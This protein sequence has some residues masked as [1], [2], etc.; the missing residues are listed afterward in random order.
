MFNWDDILDT[1]KYLVKA[2]ND[3]FDYAAQQVEALKA[4]VSNFVDDLQ[5]TVEAGLNQLVETLGGDPSEVQES[6]FE[7]LEA[8]EWFLSKL[9]GGSKQDNAKPTPKLGTQPSEDSPL[10][11]FLFH[12]I[13]AFEDAV[14]AV[15]RG[16]EGLGETIATL[17]AN[18]LKPQLAVIVMVETLRDVVIQMLGAVENLVLGFLDAI[19]EAVKQ[20]KNLLN[21]EIKIPFI[22]DLFKLI[23]AGKLTPLNLT[24]LLLAIPVT[25]VSKLMF[26][27][28]PFKNEPPLNFAPQAG[29]QSIAAPAANLR[30]ANAVGEVAIAQAV[31]EP[32]SSVQSA[33]S[34]RANS[35]RH[36]GT[37][38]LLADVINGCIT[39]YLDVLPEKAD[40]PY[41]KTAGFGFEIVS[42][43][44]SG[45]SWLASFPSSPDFPGGRPYHLLAHKVS[46]S[47]NE[48]EYWERVMWGWRTAVYWLDVVIFMGK[49]VA[50][51]NGKEVKRQ[52]L[53]R[54]DDVTI[55]VAFAFSIVDAGLAFQYLSTIP[56]A[57]KPG[58]EIANEV[59]SWLPNL[60]SPMRVTGPKGAIALSIVDGVAA[61]ANYT[62]GHRLL[63]DDL[64]EL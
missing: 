10:E 9:L 29:A 62:M 36:W 34:A 40:D 60:L 31:A 55:W 24:G 20:L 17:I 46:K 64:A 57:E 42:L 59:V 28:A 63:T 30:S 16:F 43:V 38:G 26:G 41:E 39:A 45:Y 54:A 51:A 33:N 18:P 8:V 52:R 4:P 13:E 12:F 23:G 11:H 1:Q 53:Q 37:T 27:E 48:Q 6:R 3:G 58:L 50:A 25:V 7:L 5:E 47:E 21:A 49:E 22:S 44:L 35:I 15:L 19:A 56:K 14:G 2:I 32:R 61:F